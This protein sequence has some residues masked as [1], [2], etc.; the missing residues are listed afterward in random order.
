MR[1]YTVSP[2]VPSVFDAFETFDRLFAPLGRTSQGPAYDVAQNGED[3]FRV[4]IAVPGYAENELEIIQEASELVVTGKAKTNAQSTT[5]LRRGIST[6]GFASRFQLGDNVRVSGAGL[7]NGVLGIDLVREV[8]EALKPRRI[9][10]SGEPAVE[11]QAKA[12]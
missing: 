11:G 12:A 2:P 4:A 3:R 1:L 7:V 5:W 8:P 9:Q 6:G 10:I